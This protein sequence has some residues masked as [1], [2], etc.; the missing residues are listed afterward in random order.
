MALGAREVQVLFAAV[1]RLAFLLGIGSALGLLAAVCAS[2]LLGR[3]VYQAEP[4]HP[5][6]LVGAVLTMALIG[7]CGSA[8]PALRALAVDPSTVMRDE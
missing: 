5:A 4:G 6:V 2:R 8:I 3:I 7:I 1:G